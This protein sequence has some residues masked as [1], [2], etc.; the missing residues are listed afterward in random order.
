MGD[1]RL[2]FPEHQ[3]YSQY[4]RELDLERAL[5]TV[6]YVV[7]S[8]TY[9][10]EIF[11]SLADQVIVIRLEADKPG[12]LTFT[13]SME[14]P[15]Q[16]TISTE[17]GK[18]IVL[19]G[20]GGT[21]QGVTGQIVFHALTEVRPVGGTLV[22][23][24]STLHVAN[25]D[26]APLYISI[27]TNFR[28][29]RDVSGEGRSV[30]QAHVR[31]AIEKGYAR[32][33]RDH[34][35]GYQK[36][37]DRVTIDLGTS[38]AEKE[39]TDVRVSRFASRSDPGLVALYFQFGRYLLISC[40]QPGGQPANLQGLWNDMLL[41]P[42]G[43]KYTTNINTEMNYWPSEPANLTEMSEPLVQMVRDLAESGRET[44]RSMYGA[45]GWVLHHNTDIW[46]ATAPIDGAWG[47]WPTGGAWL[48]Q[49]LWEKYLFSGDEHY[50]RSVY[51]LMKSAAEFFEDI[52]VPEPTHGWLVVSPSASPE[53]APEIHRESSS[54]G[55]TIDNQIVF[56]LMTRTIRAAD[57]L[58]VDSTFAR[59][60]QAKVDRL[61]PMQ[62]GRF[63]QLQEWLSDWDSPSDE[64]RHVSHLYGLFPSN[65]ISPRQTPELSEAAR[66]SLVH[67][68]DISTGWSMG[69]KVNLWA[70]LLDGDHAYKLIT[71]QLRL[72][73]R[74][75]VSDAGGTY[76]NL[77]D[78]HPPFQI[79]G[80]FGCT[81]GIAEMLLQ[82][83]EDA[84][85]ILPALPGAWRSG[86]ITGLRA[87]GGF[88][89]GIRWSEGR[90]Q[91]V[92]VKSSLGGVCR[93]RSYDQLAMH[94]ASG[95]REA[96]GSNVNVFFR[97]PIISK[98]LSNYQSIRV[99]PALR[100]TYLYDLPTV[101]GG[102]YVLNGTAD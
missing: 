49:Q 98:P 89:V 18:R 54:A 60:L 90:V 70:R 47:Q 97:L 83:H 24:D 67:R 71:D 42:W 66:T 81:A 20:R 5:T 27:G 21:H 11:C 44:A 78:A 14:T 39:P 41:P 7:G 6:R 51:P 72:V 1:L 61:P 93:I 86:S 10:R 48:C 91:T 82:S 55:T 88:E 69:W 8:V 102:T 94:I 64:H 76:P 77:F 50:L 12:Q 23:T 31:A 33:R 84:L 74:D 85:H 87:R 68:G 57:I 62:I 40:S 56:D 73:G 16:G 17:E 75:S 32:L 63:G 30:A 65:Q 9:T 29:Y 15:Q 58:D 37:F 34:V 96:S 4:H 43:S 79:D 92:S 3:K 28:N 45:R 80:N 53:N 22:A 99:P 52:L 100:G 26:S 36:F 2:A 25:A 101:A 19:A 38:T 13:A 35:A 95:L 59:G 46:R